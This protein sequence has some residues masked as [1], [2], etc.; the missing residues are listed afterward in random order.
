MTGRTLNPLRY[1]NGGRRNATA[2]AHYLRWRRQQNPAIP[3]RCDESQC[4]YHCEPL[5]WNGKKLPLILEHVNG[6]NSDNRPANLRLL[7]PNCDSQNVIT[8][9]GANRGRVKKYAGGF[10]LDDVDGSRAYILPAE[11]GQYVLTG[12]SIELAGP[13]NRCR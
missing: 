3:E 12:Q 6:V 5:V 2:R 7:C 1:T 11:P 9:G 10:R 4:R 8:R 13:D